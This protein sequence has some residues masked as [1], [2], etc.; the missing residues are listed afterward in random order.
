MNSFF[1]DKFANQLTLFAIGL[2]WIA[3]GAFLLSTA[4][5]QDAESR[6]Q[7]FFYDFR[8]T[9]PGTEHF[10]ESK[11]YLVQLDDESLP[12]NTCRSPVDRRWLADVL[13]AV[14]RQS[15]Q[16]VG[17]NLVLEHGNTEEDTILEN[18]ISGMGNV[19]MLDSERLPEN[20]RFKQ[21]AKSWGTMTYRLNSSRDVQY[22]CDDPSMCLCRDPKK[23]TGRKTFH[24][25]IMRTMSPEKASF[26][27][28]DRDGWMKILFLHSAAEIR[29][30]TGDTPWK[31]VSA[32]QLLELEP[33]SFEPGALVLIGTAFTDLHP[34]YRI[35]LQQLSSGRDIP[36]ERQVTSLEMTALVVEMIFNRTFLRV[37]PVWAIGILLAVCL[38]LIVAASRSRLSF[39]P[40]WIG[41]ILLLLWNVAAGLVFAY[42][43]L[44]I[45]CIVPSLAIT[46]YSL[47]CI[48]HS[49]IQ[50]EFQKLR[51]E[52]QLEKER[53]NGLVDKFHSHSVFNALEHIRF[54]VRKND[55]SAERYL[56]EYST[57]L[58]DELRHHPRQ[59]YSV[60]EQWEYVENYL[61]LQNLKH[62][63]KIQLEFALSQDSK[64]QLEEISIPWKVFYPLVE[65]AFK[66]TKPLV[67]KGPDQVP[68]IELKL[69]IEDRS[70]VFQVT[71]SF[72]DQAKI[73]GSRQGMVNLK[74]RLKFLYPKGGWHLQHNQE[75]TLWIAKLTLPV[76]KD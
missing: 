41:L 75:G 64:E 33:R 54:L 38:L 15:P 43:L 23:C 56:M 59:K 50:E 9:L 14:Q 49:Q 53:F 66:Y 22:V 46:T 29:R 69:E 73:P 57:L 26:H 36:R 2:I 10:Q 52:N 28:P 32:D 60:V 58:L 31:I 24:R 40:L 3:G 11:I 70:L 16:A 74:K 19:V 8:L 17:L 42:Y 27:F 67:Q 4:L 35:P 18:V 76:S 12:D 65:N 71:N 6:W 39:T 47:F 72:V 34:G 62:D 13:R 21:A 45:S 44:E 1:D 20:D 25:E 51:L 37:V 7:R 61:N 55:P 48:R 68:R 5:F 63:G 30:N